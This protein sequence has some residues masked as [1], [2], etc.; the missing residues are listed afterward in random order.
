M[1]LK[2]KTEDVS[3]DAAL[4]VVCCHDAPP[5]AGDGKD[6]EDSTA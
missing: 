6:R 3:E 1:E 2:P 5:I 4:Y